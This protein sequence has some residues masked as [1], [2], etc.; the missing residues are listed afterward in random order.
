MKPSRT[1]AAIEALIWALANDADGNVRSSAAAALG[2]IGSDAAIEALI[3]ALT[4]AA[5]GN[6]RSSAAAALGSIGY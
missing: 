5:D 2:S 4:N 6:V 1:N 3:W